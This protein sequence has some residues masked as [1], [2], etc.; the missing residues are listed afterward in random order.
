MKSKR[1]GK[2]ISDVEIHTTQ[3]GIW[4]L[5]QDIEYF[6]SYKDYPWFRDSTLSN[7]YDVKL[8]HGHHLRWEAL[9]ID[10]ELEA[11]QFPERYPLIYSKTK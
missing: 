6:L 3:F 9:D 5:I 1:L 2:T 4:L 7:L 8:L 10:L 11:L